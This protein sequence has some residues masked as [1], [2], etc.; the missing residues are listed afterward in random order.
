MWIVFIKYSNQYNNFLICINIVFDIVIHFSFTAIMERHLTDNYEPASINRRR[1]TLT[2][3]FATKTL[4][5]LF[6]ISYR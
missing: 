3:D 1:V 5:R 4:E 6:S 2:L